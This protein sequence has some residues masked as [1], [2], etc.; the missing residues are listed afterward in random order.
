[1]NIAKELRYAA[2][3]IKAF[4][5]I[6]YYYSPAQYDN[7]AF[8]LISLFSLKMLEPEDAVML[9]KK[10][11]NDING[12]ARKYHCNIIEQKTQRIFGR[13]CIATIMIT[14]EGTE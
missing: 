1:M 3:M 13:D 6:E 7:K 12:F 9:L 5:G 8:I 4:S 14:P 10:A 2:K 11:T